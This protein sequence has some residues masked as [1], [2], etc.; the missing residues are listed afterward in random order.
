MSY[1]LLI[2]FWFVM[3]TTVVFAN[4]DMIMETTEANRKILLLI[5][6]IFSPAFLL[7][8][9]L[10]TVITFLLPEDEDNWKNGGG[11]IT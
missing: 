9:S 10:E 4:K 5:F 7:V 8:E 1:I 11:K 6:I 2:F 3:A